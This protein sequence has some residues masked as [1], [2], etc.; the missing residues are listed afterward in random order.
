MPRNTPQASDEGHLTSRRQK[1]RP[2]SPTVT[3]KLKPV[4][5]IL[6]GVFG[7]LVVLV[8]FTLIVSIEEEVRC[9]GTVIPAEKVDIR[10]ERSAV[11]THFLVDVGQQVSQ[12]DSLATLYAVPAQQGLAR[13]EQTCAQ[14][15][16][17]VAAAQAALAMVEKN[18]LPDKLWFTD[19]DVAEA[20]ERLE[21]SKHSYERAQLLFEKQTISTEEHESA[22]SAY[23]LSQ[24]QLDR[25]QHKNEMAHSGI[26]EATIAQ[27]RAQVDLAEANLLA[28]ETELR[29]AKEE[30]ERAVIV[31][32]AVGVVTSVPKEDGERAEPGEL[33][34]QIATGPGAKLRIYIDERS[35]FKV[36]L[37]QR[38]QIR[39]SAY[40][41][42]KHGVCWGVVDKLQLWAELRGQRNFYE[43]EVTVTEAPFELPLGSSAEARV[44]VGRKPILQILLSQ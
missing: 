2:A 41:Y 12:G 4:R 13:A 10:A 40:P 8:A 16:A 28:A 32:P 27:A 9:L 44:R 6:L 30:L 39:S 25:E 43:A 35:V 3:K 11:V 21:V 34:V 24:V 36:A 26:R 17:E 38:V 5:Y 1:E 20:Q 7:L 22:L 33:L 19:E 31:A 42:L 29:L 23:R 14:R 18:P 15:R 37:G